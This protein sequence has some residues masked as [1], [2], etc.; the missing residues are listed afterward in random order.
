V[1]VNVYYFEEDSGFFDAPE[2][3]R[4][5]GFGSGALITSAFGV[6]ALLNFSE[7][8]AL[9]L[10]ASLNLLGVGLTFRF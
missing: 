1:A 8:V 9:R 10:D 4:L 5:W 7:S 6:G 2:N 3:T